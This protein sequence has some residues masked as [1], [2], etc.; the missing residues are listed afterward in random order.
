MG[1]KMKVD[2]KLVEQVGSAMKLKFSDQE[3]DHFLNEIEDTLNML[4]KLSEL[5]TEGIEPTFYGGPKRTA[6]LRKDVAIKNEDEVKALLD[7][8]PAHTEQHIKVPA[9][10]D[11]GEGGA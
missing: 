11:D 7:N 8:A 2:K 6:R 5:D 1:E 10:L 4:E 3:V 9:I